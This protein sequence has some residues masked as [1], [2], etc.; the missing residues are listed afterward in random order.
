MGYFWIPCPICGEM[1]GGHEARHTSSL[2]VKPYHGK[3][4]CAKCSAE[5]VRRNTENYGWTEW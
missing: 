1:F 2:W 3:A 4:V 5:A